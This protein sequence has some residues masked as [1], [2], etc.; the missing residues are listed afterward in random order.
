[1]IKTAKTIQ[2]SRI[3]HN[4]PNGH[5]RSECEKYRRKFNVGVRKANAM[6]KD[7]LLAVGFSLGIAC[8]HDTVDEL[9]EM[10][11]GSY[12]DGDI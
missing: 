7:E 4:I 1:M 5:N 3:A 12:A 9:R 6:H 8:D 2:D 11:A 10:Y